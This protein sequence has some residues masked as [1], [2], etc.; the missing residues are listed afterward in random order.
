MKGS[1]FVAF[2]LS[3]ALS[4]QAQ[5]KLYEQGIDAYQKKDYAKAIDLFNEY[6][7]KPTRDKALDVDVHYYLALSYFKTNS[8][9]SSV[10]E[11][12]EALKAGH[13]NAGNIHWFMAKSYA[14]LRAFPDALSSYG[15]AVELITDKPNQAKLLYERARIYEKMGNLAL[16]QEDLDGALAADPTHAEAQSASRDLSGGKS[17]PA[18]V[19]ATQTPVVTEQKVADNKSKQNKNNQKGNPPAEKKAAGTPPAEKK[20]TGTPPL[21]TPPAT[22]VTSSATPTL[23]DLYKDEK[24]YALVIGNSNYK[25]VSPLRNAEN[26]ANDIAAELKKSDFEVFKV[27]NGDYNQMRD[28]FRKFHE[29]LATGPK[30][31]TVGLFYYAGHGIQNQGENYLVPVDANVQYEDDIPRT[32]M[33]VQRIIMANMERSN[34]RINIMI[35]DACRNNPFPSGYRSAE[36][37]LAE[38]RRAKGSFIAYATAPGSVASDGEGRNGLYTQELLNAM[39]KP[40]LTIEQVF[41]EVRKN[42]MHLSGERQYTWDSSNI[43]GDFYFKF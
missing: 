6:L 18:N 4:A 17:I 27:I 37:G 36:S 11:F 13:K 34:T 41:K 8:H 32:C 23:A 24:R 3:L 21:V 29:K 19:P 39:K 12:D 9:T 14:E 33:P 28:A 26:D 20:A 15:K 25:Y 30:D 22:V 40:G 35:L 31:Q 1:V 16:A 5:F 2:F 10:R 42:V 7:D 43:I 38:V